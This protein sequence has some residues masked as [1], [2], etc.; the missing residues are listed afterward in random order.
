[1][2]EQVQQRKAKANHDYWPVLPG[3]VAGL[4]LIMAMPTLA[5]IEDKPAEETG[6]EAAV[7]RSVDESVSTPPPPEAGLET[8]VQANIPDPDWRPPSSPDITVPS[9]VSPEQA[10]HIAEQ[11]GVRLLSLRLSAAGYMMD[12]RFRVLD[13]DKA[14]PLFDY[15]ISPYVVAKRTGISLPVPVAAKIG[16]FRPTNRG[17]NIKPNRNYYMMFANPDRH[18]KQGD[19]VDL[20]I[21]EF[22]V[23][24]LTLN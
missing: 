16:A 13:V 19:K 12:F 22:K 7:L 20:I 17:R 9:P 8:E 5:S 4:A 18:V 21:G 11:W 3:L 2:G 6:R 14:L 24:G 10:V 1:M 15:R 23:E